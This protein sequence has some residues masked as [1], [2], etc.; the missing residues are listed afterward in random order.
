LIAAGLFIALLG[1]GLA[2]GLLLTVGC[3][4]NVHPGTRRDVCNAFTS[5]ALAWWLAVLWPAAL[6]ASSWVVPA[7]RRRG[8]LAGI[9]VAALAVVFWTI[10]LGVVST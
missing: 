10:L 1:I 4:E 7:L 6:Y 3:S 8:V 9:V 5:G 2:A